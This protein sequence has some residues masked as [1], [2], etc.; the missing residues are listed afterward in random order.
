MLVELAS[1][2]AAAVRRGAREGGSMEA[3]RRQQADD[4]D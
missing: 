2:F 3:L 1:R 4:D